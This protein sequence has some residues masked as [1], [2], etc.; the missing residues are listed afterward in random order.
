M[1]KVFL[2]TN[3]FIGLANKVPEVDSEIFDDHEG[4]ISSLSCHILFYVNKIKVPDA[5]INSFVDDFNIISLNHDILDRA[6][7]NPTDDLEDNIQL[8]SAIAADCDFFLTFDQK[9][10]K[11]KFFGKTKIQS[12]LILHA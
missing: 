10:L 1:A 8:H 11:L 9:L 4:F 7:Q 5:K 2:D 12:G 6:L 3:Y